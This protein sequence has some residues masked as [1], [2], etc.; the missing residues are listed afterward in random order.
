MKLKA[1]RRRP[2]DHTADA[3]ADLA[4]FTGGCCLQFKGVSV[5]SLPTPSPPLCLHHTCA[6]G[7]NDAAA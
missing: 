7:H 1:V 5:R 3:L 6:A 4:T 2:V